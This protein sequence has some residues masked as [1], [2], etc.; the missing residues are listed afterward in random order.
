MATSGWVSRA[1]QEPL[2]RG[3]SCRVRVS[4]PYLHLRNLPHWAPYL[5]CKWS[6]HK[7]SEVS[8]GLLLLY[9]GTGA[10]HEPSACWSNRA[11]F[12]VP[13]HLCMNICG[14]DATECPG[15]S[16]SSISMPLSYGFAGTSCESVFDHNLAQAE[17]KVQSFDVSILSSGLRK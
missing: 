17:S 14:V 12:S 3:C 11:C 15:S 9:P 8:G 5:A 6:S 2:P 4:Q 7:L 1:L 13:Q 16:P 10:F